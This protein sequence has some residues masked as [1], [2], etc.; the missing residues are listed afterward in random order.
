MEELIEDIWLDMGQPGN[1][2]VEAEE[3]IKKRYLQVL[4]LRETMV[5]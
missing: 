3:E 5:L 4:K 1:N 2:I